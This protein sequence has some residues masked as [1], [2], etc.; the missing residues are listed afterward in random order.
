MG[1]R[2]KKS[3]KLMPGVKI[4]I[5]KKGLNSV[6]LGGKGASVNLGKKGRRT[7]VGIPGTGMSYTSTSKRR[8]SSAKRSSGGCGGLI[9]LVVIVLVVIWLFF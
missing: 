2:F 8:R 6:S 9:L 7:T 1:F 4:N 3:I 5:S